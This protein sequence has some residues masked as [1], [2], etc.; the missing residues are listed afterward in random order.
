MAEY[1]KTL[2]L[3]QEEI[4]ELK[5]GDQLYLSGTIYTGRDAAHKRLIETLDRGEELPFKI[6]NSALYYVGPCPAKPG[7]IIGSCGP[8]TSYRMDDYT[9]PLLKRGLKIMIGKGTRSQEV[10]ESMIENK[11][12]YLAAIGGAGA[13][14]KSSIKESKIIAYEDL[15]TEAIR[16]LKVIEFPAI[17]A[18]DAFGKSLYERK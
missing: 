4:L 13:L 17:V 16:E 12:I 8:T 9:I 6:K 5:A 1:Y 11:A 10:I 7:E 14:I 18:I 2:P 3:S 15:E